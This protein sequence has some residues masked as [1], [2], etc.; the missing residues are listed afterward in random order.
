ME[1]RLMSWSLG[2]VM[3]QMRRAG[4]GKGRVRD[5]LGERWAA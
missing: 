4:P 3:D 1:R 2:K 5:G